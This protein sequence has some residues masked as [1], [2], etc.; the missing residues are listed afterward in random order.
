VSD[1]ALFA[2]LKASI[3]EFSSRMAEARAELSKT[4]AHGS[5]LGSKFA[6]IG[7]GLV[8]GL[9]GAAVAV[10]AVALEMAD[11][12][13]TAHARLVSAVTNVGGSMQQLHGQ[14]T[15]VDNKLQNFGFTN[16][17]TESA[18][19]RLVPAVKD[20]AKALGEMGLA[21]D[22]ARGRNID[23]QTAT[24][25]LVKVQTGHVALLGRLGIATKDASGH[26]I[27][28][29]E[30][31]KRLAEMY[32]G[33]AQANANTFAGRMQALKA[34]GEDLAKN[35]GVALIPV[36][37]RLMQIT[38]QVVDWFERHRTVAVALGVVV[39]TVLVAAMVAYAAA[40]AAAAASTIAAMAP[41][42]AVAAAVAALAAG[43]IYAYTHWRVFHDAVQAVASFV[44]GTLWPALQ[45]IAGFLA[46]VFRAAVQTSIDIFT[47]LKTVAVD[48][49]TAVSTAVSTAWG[50]LRPI[51]EFIINVALI[52]I[53]V[54]MKL[55][56]DLWNAAWPAISTAVSTAWGV[57][58]GPFGL[59]V[60]TG[61]TA[62]NVAVTA[63]QTAFSI[64]WDVISTAV[65]TAWDLIR[66]IF[67]FI[68]KAIDDIAGPLGTVIGDIGKFASNPTGALSH[69]PGV[70]SL[71]RAAGGPVSAGSPYIVGEK[72]PELFMPGQ[73]GSIAPHGSFGGGQ[74]ITISISGNT[75]VGTGGITELA[76]AIRRELIRIGVRQG[77]AS[78][79]SGILGGLA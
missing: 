18:L 14:L 41:F 70:G 39:G 40:A 32:G 66:P 25:I 46:T 10:G 74:A 48:V 2:E 57:V 12:W 6:T 56:A 8:V 45:Q 24:D 33:A 73:S 42:I 51:F 77:G 20:P 71:F 53:R 60:D 22:I 11:K 67:G 27:S 1:F 23:L 28:Q 35:I 21:A 3:S 5:S 15:A 76:E 36:I 69:I 38:M 64:A 59:I 63:L 7:Q 55:L 68:K 19:A 37:E 78:T 43:V 65:S 58:K 29:T 9:G 17:E 49:W 13:E 79:G 44:T 16:A 54:A 4:E 52:P 34:T 47:T 31:L 26:T 75:L 61:L 62:I 72:G 50:V 30:A